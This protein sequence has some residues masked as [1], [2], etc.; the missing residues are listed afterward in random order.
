MSRTVVTG[1]LRRSRGERGMLL[2]SAAL[3]WVGGAWSFLTREATGVLVGI[4]AGCLCGV[5]HHLAWRRARANLRRHRWL[6]CPA[7][8][9]PLDPRQAGGRCPECGRPWR[10]MSVRRAWRRRYAVYLA[11]PVGLPPGA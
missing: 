4:S 6:R 10:R 5:G 8:R 7:C 11:D 3:P 1:A 9:H 2:A